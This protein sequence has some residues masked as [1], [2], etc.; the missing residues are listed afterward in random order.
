VLKTAEEELRDVS[1]DLPRA[2]GG[3]ESKGPDGA[4]TEAC[5]PDTLQQ[6][7]G[8][9]QG[10]DR[11]P[12]TLTKALTQK[13]YMDSIAAMRQQRLEERFAA[14][15][16]L[17]SV[18]AS[19]SQDQSHAPSPPGPQASYVQEKRNKLFQRVAAL[20]ERAKVDAASAR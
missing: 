19:S 17:A 8:Q 16:K 3:E 15:K 1:I 5:Q 20:M 4:A 9:G 10:Q 7:Q 6:E 2:N 13:A 14:G 11:L 18:R 12:S